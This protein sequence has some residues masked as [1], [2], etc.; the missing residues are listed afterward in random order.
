MK[1]I[2]NYCV[3][4]A[5]LVGL[6]ACSTSAPS[7]NTHTY[8][9]NYQHLKDYANKQV[10]KALKQH[11]IAAMHVLVLDG[12]TVV[13][14]QAFG[15]ADKEQGIKANND[16]AY[17]IGSISKLFTAT[18]IMQLHEQ[19]KLDIDQ[20]LSRYLPGFSI[21]SDYDTN[22]ITLRR[23]MSHHSG[24]PSDFIK[25]ANNPDRKGLL[26]AL[27][28]TY[29]TAAPDTIHSYSNLAYGLLGDVIEQV[30]GLSYNE[31]MQRF[32][33]L[34]SNM[35]GAQSGIEGTGQVNLAKAYNAGEKQAHEMIRDTA[36][37][38][39]NMSATD[40]A[41]FVKASFTNS[42]SNTP[43]LQSKTLQEMWR[44]QNQTVALDNGFKMGLGWMLSKPEP[45]LHKM[46]NL[47][48]HSGYVGHFNSSLLVDTRNQLA[49]IV[50]S[51]SEEAGNTVDMLSSELL[52]KAV[53]SK[54]GYQ[55]AP[56]E[57]SRK[58]A[59]QFSQIQLTDLPGE[60]LSPYLGAFTVKR[61]G[62]RLQF[63][64][65]E[66]KLSL[67]PMDDGTISASYKLFNLI[68]V[69]DESLHNLRIETF[70]YHGQTLI[71]AKN[72]PP[73]AYK[74]KPLTLSDEWQKS[75][76]D[77]IDVTDY[78]E[79]GEGDWTITKINLS[80]YHGYIRAETSLKSKTSDEEQTD[81][82]Y[83]K[84]ASKNRAVIIGYGRDLGNSLIMS[85][86]KGETVISFSGLRFKQIKA[87]SK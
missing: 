80:N 62:S 87:D 20:P 42:Q 73:I 51:N 71:R 28:K 6:L 30:S 36:A 67:A 54:T 18:A 57:P 64:S 77:Y 65:E 9:D 17:R 25:G 83:F 40:L 84:P 45:L 10:A 43:L 16:T 3:L 33:F 72:G 50:L 48:W 11:D 85:N 61:K 56:Y 70:N 74:I 59:K 14:N 19:G 66:A 7:Q 21:Q 49:V 55:H 52:I 81:V 34:P 38:D 53:A 8:Q 13:Y 15:D 82:T 58:K 75:L 24:L 69:Y 44:V 27:S 78:G 41:Q 76:G 12:Q 35:Q 2:I 23:M 47:A 37:G 86:V 31:Y 60:Y 5:S 22:G 29:T 26:E 4:L 46:P 79:S 63:I 68:P 39:L 32:L 1:P